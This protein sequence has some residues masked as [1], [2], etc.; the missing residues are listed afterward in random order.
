M[1]NFAKLQIF[2]IRPYTQ[3]VF[4]CGSLLAERIV[5]SRPPPPAIAV[6]AAWAHMHPNTA[7]M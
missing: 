4:S 3:A 2:P 7:G 5:Y 1:E 6:T